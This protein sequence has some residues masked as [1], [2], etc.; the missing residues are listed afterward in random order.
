[1]PHFVMQLNLH[2]A[3]AAG[4]PPVLLGTAGNFAILAKTGVSTVPDSVVGEYPF[5]A[6]PETYVH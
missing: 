5:T 3:F 4:P 2:G 1:M 6:C